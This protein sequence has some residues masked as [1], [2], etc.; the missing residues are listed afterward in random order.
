MHTVVSAI[1]LSGEITQSA[2]FCIVLC[3]C[4]FS[5]PLYIYD[6]TLVF[7]I[8]IVSILLCSYKLS[9]LKKFWSSRHGSVVNES[10]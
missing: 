9:N 8:I 4:G 2:T 7:L 3:I 10:D 5:Y 6:K 1:L